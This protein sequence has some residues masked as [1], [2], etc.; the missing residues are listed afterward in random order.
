MDLLFLMALVEI[1]IIRFIFRAPFHGSLR[2]C[3]SARP[4]A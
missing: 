4:Y 3:S 1:G 2:L